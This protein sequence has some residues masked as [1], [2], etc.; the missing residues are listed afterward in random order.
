MK[1][2]KLFDCICV[3]ENVFKKGLFLLA[4][5]LVPFLS[6]EAQE[7]KTITGTVVSSDGNM[8]IPGVNVLVKGTNTGAVTDFDGNFSI[9]ANAN[10]IL[11][12]TYLGFQEQEVVVGPQNILSVTLEEATAALDEIVVVGYGT[13]K[14]SDLTGSIAI[15]DASEAQKVS[16][17]DVS[18][19]LQGR[20]A[21]VTVTSGGQPGAAPNV[22]IRGVATFGDNQPLYIVDGVPVGTSI[23]DFNPNDIQSIQVLKDASAGAIYGSRAANGVVII[24]TKKGKKSSPLKIEYSGYYGIDEVAQNIPVLGREDYQMI[25]NEKRTNAGLP[26]ILGNDPNSD[27][28]V[29]NINTDWQDVGLKSGTRQNHNFNF[30][31]GG[32]NITYNASVDYFKNEGVFVGNGPSYERYSGRINT[33]MEKGIFKISPSIYYSHSFE[34]SLTFRGDILSGGRPPLINDLI[35]SIPTLGVFDENNEGGY[36]GT[37]SQIH[38]AIVLNVP[39]INSLFTNTVEVDRTFAIINPEVKLIDTDNH[40]L[41]YKLNM[42]YDKTVARDFSFV[43]EFEMGYFFN[44]GRSLLDDNS[45]QYTV[46]LIENTLNYNGTFGKHTFDVLLGQTYQKN[47]AI[48][49]TAH[50]ENLPKPYYPIL[51]NGNNQTVGGNEVYSSLASLFGRLNYNFDDRYLIT[52]TVRRDG[53]SRFAPANK[54][55]TFPSL[56]LGWRVSNEDFFDRAKDVVSNFKLRA[57]YGQLGNQNIGDYLYQPTINRNIPYNF[58]G[59]KVTG[60]LQT[61]IVSEDIKWETTTSLNIGADLSFFKGA[62]DFTAEYYNKETTDV[63]VGVPIPASVGSI[64][65]APV[66][67]AGSLRNSGF[68]FEVTYHSDP[69]R[70]F[71]FDVSANASTVKNKVLALGGNNEPIYGVGS[72]TQVGSEIGQHFGYVYEGIFQS[73][74]EIAD[75][76]FQSALTA[77]GDVKFQDLN[78]DGVIGQEDRKFLGS[79]I[80]SLTY[81]LN[82]TAQYKNFDFTVFASGA[83]GYY[84]NSSL[85]RSLMWSTD[86]IN[87]HEDILNRWTPTNTDTNIPRVVANDPNGNARDSNRPGWLQ[88]G[89]YLRINTVSIGYTI[90]VQNFS[91]FFDSTRIYGTVQNLHT[92]QA[93]KGFNPDFASGVFEPGFDNGTYPRPRTFLLGV[94][95]SF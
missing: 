55:G 6:S 15:I 10:D 86:Y 31:G 36:A 30:S 9:E 82:F 2:N 42:S 85:Y 58:G 21:G 29:D 90:P 63:L 7:I 1:Q 66:V 13:Q 44:S 8:P 49:R 5:M 34:N 54:Y 33:V 95:L 80:P 27:L 60:G 78:G 93:Y 20:S 50:S 17:S 40:K 28:F 25:V 53:S 22:R 39:G 24:T 48:I 76:A 57:S 92:F 74:D 62:L 16:N 32:E 26:L 94:E 65:T 3:L 89:D 45:R 91:D 23:R 81:G 83:A 71:T 70:A 84:I 37:S 35:I 59:N 19:L 73:Q 69:T 68:D 67:N 47:S 75:H 11:I 77:P 18:Q 61:S 43:P 56:A 46:S 52:A 51:A 38:Q 72:K 64:N 79:A 12:F 14:K 41:T 4:F 87:S 88:K